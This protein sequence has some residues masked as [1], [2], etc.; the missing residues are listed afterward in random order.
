M[1]SR[2]QSA[3]AYP[4][5]GGRYIRQKLNPL[6]ELLA[7]RQGHPARDLGIVL[8]CKNTGTRL[9]EIGERMSGMDYAAV[10]QACKR[11]EKR[12]ESERTPARAMAK[13]EHKLNRIEC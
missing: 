12:I 7:K 10:S 13:I 9:M 5:T 3:P 4:P 1:D 8:C 2:F 6:W 11:M